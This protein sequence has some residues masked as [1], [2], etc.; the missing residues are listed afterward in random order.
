MPATYPPGLT[1]RPI[2]AWPGALTSPRRRSPFSA[3]WS[4]T[5]QLLTDELR[6]LGTPGR[7]A[8]AVLQIAMR[9]QDFRLD[10][11]PRANSQP[12]HP[13]V[14]LTIDTAT[15]GTLSFPSDRFVDWQDNLRAIALVLEALRKIDRY[16]ITP[17]HEQYTGWRQLTA[18]E[19]T[20]RAA[21]AVLIQFGDGLGEG[22]S[23]RDVYRRAVKATHP[24]RG[25]RRED[26]ERVQAA[27][28]RLGVAS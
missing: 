25:G 17:G 12:Q 11:L 3:R 20:E 4:A 27:A 13:G 28:E 15:Q 1:L 19:P 18:T 7:P 23:W 5:L 14:I 24:D 2:E 26:F 16:G 22:D 8:A 10:G 6:H 9:E 21:Q